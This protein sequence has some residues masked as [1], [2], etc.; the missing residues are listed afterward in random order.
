LS[1]PADLPGRLD[2]PG[3]PVGLVIA[4]PSVVPADRTR[5]PGTRFVALHANGAHQDLGPGFATSL[6]KPVRF[7]DLLGAL[8]RLGDA[9]PAAGARP[10]VGA[11]RWSRPVRVLVAEDNAVNQMVAL[12]LLKKLGVAADVAGNGLEAIRALQRAPYD[13][14]LMDVQMPEMDGLA[15]TRW[16]RDP[17]NRISVHEIP[18]IAMTANA[19]ASDRADCQAAG[20]SDFVSKPVMLPALRAALERWLPVEPGVSDPAPRPDPPVPV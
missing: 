1:D 9:A 5:W 17:G 8:R 18:I 15:A 14:V 4:S 2:A 13:L 20:M 3:A 7:A 12:G 6:S 10:A 19:M 11:P 16:I